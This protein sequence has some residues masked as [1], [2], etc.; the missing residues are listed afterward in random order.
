MAGVAEEKGW[1]EVSKKIKIFNKKDEAN[2]KYGQ[3]EIYTRSM[4]GKDYFSQAGQDL[5]ALTM[6]QEKSA[7]WYLEIG[8]AHPFESNNTFILESKY[9]WNGFS[10]EYDEPM[11]LEYNSAR[12]NPCFCA[13][14]TCFDYE[15]KFKE[16]G[17]PSRVDYLSIDIDPAENTYKAL[18]ILPFDKYRFSVITFEHDLYSS[19]PIYMELSRELLNS[20]GYQLVAQNVRC[21]GRVFEDWWVDPRVI[22]E[23]VWSKYLFVDKEFEDIF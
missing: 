18:T 17:F 8:G 19:G 14:A 6:L 21:F 20:K 3:S 23:D 13:D 15:S 11:S 16:L 4:K 22:S 2:S 9:G 1:S 7:G 5:F 10:L 12:L